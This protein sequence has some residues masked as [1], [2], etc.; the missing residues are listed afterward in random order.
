[1]S[2][3]QFRINGDE[4]RRKLGLTSTCFSWKTT[5]TGLVFTVI[6]YGHG[7]GLCQYGAAGMAAAG[8]R[9]PEILR[10]YYRGIKFKKIKY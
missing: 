8:R 6:G 4:F 1:L 2:F 5:Q 10:H 7:V 9:Y 3:G